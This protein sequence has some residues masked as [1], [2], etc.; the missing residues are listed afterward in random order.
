MFSF[1]FAGMFGMFLKYVDTF[2][3]RS[4]ERQEGPHLAR[5]LPA[6]CS[7]SVGHIEWNWEW[8]DC[9]YVM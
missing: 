9:L 4:E 8:L 2:V 6:C 1:E 3:W 5:G 7:R